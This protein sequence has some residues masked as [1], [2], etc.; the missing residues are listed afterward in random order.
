MNS[1]QQARKPLYIT[2]TFVNTPSGVNA[3]GEGPLHPAL[4][5]GK[6]RNPSARPI[7][8]SGTTTTVM[9]THRAVSIQRFSVLPPR[10]DLNCIFFLRLCRHLVNSSLVC[11][12]HSK[13]SNVGHLCP[14]GVWGAQHYPA[15]CAPSMLLCNPA[16]FSDIVQPS[17]WRRLLRRS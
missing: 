17:P 6:K 9:R 4:I 8:W 12:Y 3:A 2:C 13:C 10:K 5:S 16:C 15:L 14:Q 7:R 11:K 1:S